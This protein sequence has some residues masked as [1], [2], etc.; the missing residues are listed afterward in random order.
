MHTNTEF[1]LKCCG[2]FSNLHKFLMEVNLN[3]DGIMEMF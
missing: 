2:H 1:N 3:C